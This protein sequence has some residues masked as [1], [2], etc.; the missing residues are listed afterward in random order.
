MRAAGCTRLWSE[1][2]SDEALARVGKRESVADRT[3][4]PRKLLVTG[5]PGK[6][7]EPGYRAASGSPADGGRGS[8]VRGHQGLPASDRYGSLSLVRADRHELA[9]FP[10]LPDRPESPVPGQGQRSRTSRTFRPDGTG[11]RDLRPY[12]IN[13]GPGCDGHG[14]GRAGGNS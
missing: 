4:T 12:R 3:G 5:C 7:D 1:S 13:P 11:R 9:E 2:I 14:S 10:V 8:A 6:P